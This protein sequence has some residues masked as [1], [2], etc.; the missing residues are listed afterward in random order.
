M[1]VP[2]TTALVCPVLLARE[3]QLV[4]LKGLIAQM[5]N[6]RGQIVLITGEAGVGKSRLVAAAQAQAQQH[7]IAL[8][9]GRCFEPDRVLPYAPLLDLLR[10]WVAAHAADHV[11][12]MLGPVAADL[13]RLLP[14]LAALVPD[15]PPPRA[16]EPEQEQHRH[17][18]ALTQFFTRV[19]TL[20]PVLVVLEDLHWSDEAS[21]EVALALARRTPTLP[22]LLVLTY[23]SDEIP[24]EL[25]SFLA[26]LDRE[27][28]A[29]DMPLQRL[30]STD[31]AAMIR[32]IFDV[33]RPPPAAFVEALYTI[34]EGN[35][36]FVEEMLK[37]L[38]AAGDLAFTSDDW[39]RI[40]LQSLH[41]PRSVQIAVQQRL[42]QLSAEAREVLTLA[43]VTGRRF[44]FDLLQMLTGHDDMTLIRL[45]KELI[46]AQLVVEESADSFAFRHALTRQA[47]EG[48]LLARERRAL[49]R[50]IAIA[51]EQ[52]YAER[53]D[54]HLADLA[55]HC[56]AAELWDKTVE[57][58]R[59]AGEAAQALYAPRAAIAL[60]T[61]AI[62][63]AQR[64]RQK[65]NPDL[66]LAC[67]HMHDMLGA[68]DAAHA[69]YAQALDTARDGND[70]AIAWRGL[71]ALGWLWTGR[72]YG[73]AGEYFQQAIALARTMDDPSTLAYTLNRVGNWHTHAE[74][75]RAGLSYHQEALEI[76][77]ATGDRAGQAATLDL[78]AITSYMG[79][80]MISGTAYYEQAVNLFRELGDQ[81]GLAACL[82][83]F[84]TRGASPMHD[85]MV[86]PFVELSSCIRDG[87]EAIALARQI[88]WRAGEAQELMYLGLGLGPRGQYGRALEAT[89]AC[90]AIA[91]E[92]G[93][94][95]WIA[96]GQFTLSAIYLDLLALPLAREHAERAFATAR[97]IDSRFLICT[98]TSF[99]ALICVAQRDLTRAEALLDAVLDQD[100]PSETLAQRLIW[101]ARAELALARKD[102]AEALRIVD[103]LRASA[104][105]LTPGHTIA[106]LWY[107]RAQALL[108]LGHFD[109]AG[110][111][112]NE[113]LAD[114]QEHS[115]LA[116]LWRILA[117]LGRLYRSQGQ[118]DS[119]EQVVAEARTII[120]MLT[121][122]IPDPALRE[123]FVASADAQLPHLRSPSPLRTARQ[124]Y[125]GLTARE[126]EVAALIAQ[127]LSNRA[128]AEALVLSE[129]TIAKHVENILSK[130]HFTSRAQIAA[131][132][133]E[134]GLAGSDRMTS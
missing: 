102:Y 9:Q 100:A 71:Q 132:A 21:L 16:I 81:Q 27:R 24:A 74:Q 87:E 117:A 112:L 59:Q 46:R 119:M 61:R 124:T 130:L 2:F 4:A 105:N 82:G 107:L 63:A 75:P 115:H 76:F 121:A 45:I 94:R 3:P 131:W 99:L 43:A 134:K 67:G 92:I 129:R 18:Q 5:C 40:P 22:L 77:A 57:Y 44:D 66:Y 28:L 7:G 11:R 72:D 126:R 38:S 80:D 17:I 70:P 47:V 88:D 35:P 19:A 8:L 56:W 84:A 73:R 114:A 113:A 89:Q 62:E 116:L 49:H 101:R 60:Y 36:F 98:A 42:N 109:E 37:S 34:T 133:V 110:T 50:T 13:V 91:E 86:E 90:L 123:T 32:S 41:L 127:G 48:D 120:G 118:R 103:Q 26:A 93:H 52:L 104:M 85:T 97:A 95:A 106:R 65:P 14:D 39:N 23:R 55:E 53:L 128:L 78:L 69:D 33:S 6:G 108:G 15:L 96:G 122:H 64:L 125:D 31:V 30:S 20:G 111:M 68:F 54:T 10:G 79:G 25:G 29:I 83:P 58:A 12:T 1:A 51:M